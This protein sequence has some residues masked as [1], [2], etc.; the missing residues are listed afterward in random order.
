M[1]IFNKTILYTK[2]F[3][4]RVDFMLSIISTKKITIYESS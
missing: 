2:I 3:V 1:V 4:K